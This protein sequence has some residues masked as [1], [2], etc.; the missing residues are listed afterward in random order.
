MN[1]QTPN[2]QELVN[3]VYVNMQ[4]FQF[5]PTEHNVATA[6]RCMQDLKTLYSIVGK[7][8]DE[9]VKTQ[10]VSPDVGEV[11]PVEVVTIV[12]EEEEHE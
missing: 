2:A 9:L 3:Q 11:P 7:M 10:S 5:Q 8:Q 4:N 12:P 1:E 6:M